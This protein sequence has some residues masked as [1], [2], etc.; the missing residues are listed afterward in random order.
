MNTLNAQH[1]MCIYV[2]VPIFNFDMHRSLEEKRVGNKLLGSLKYK[3][4]F[5]IT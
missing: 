2:F 3:K 1:N 4:C 5:R